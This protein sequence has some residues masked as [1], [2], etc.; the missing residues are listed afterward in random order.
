VSVHTVHPGA[1]AT[2]ITLHA[3]YHDSSTEKFH[4]TLQKGTSPAGAAKI[5]LDGVLKNK[6][7][8]MISDG[9]AQDL[10]ARLLPES[11]IPVVKGIMKLK[12]IAIR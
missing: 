9:A 12:K 2:D 11:Y 5:I 6:G 3:D 4:Q 7:R 1:V 10:L 8:I